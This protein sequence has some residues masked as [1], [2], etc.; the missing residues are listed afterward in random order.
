ETL[1]IQAA[2]AAEVSVSQSEVDE[3]FGRVASNFK[4][5]P[6]QFAA[7]IKSKGSSINSLKRQI[8][9]EMSWQRVLG[10]K[11]EPFVNVGDD[12]VKSLID[13]LDA[14]KGTQEYRVQEI[15]LSATPDTNADILA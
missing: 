8:K 10:R 2:K 1:Q 7:F 13:R 14:Q 3:A 9:G 5:S 15:F 4:S 12:E 6:T 11:V